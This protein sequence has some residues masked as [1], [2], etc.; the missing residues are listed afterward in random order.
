M[1]CMRDRYYSKQQEMQG[2]D[3]RGVASE[4]YDVFF[5][6]IFIYFIIFYDFYWTLLAILHFILAG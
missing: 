1:A 6:L 4:L 2:N 3:E 5:N